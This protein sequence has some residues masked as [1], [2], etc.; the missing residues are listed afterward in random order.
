MPNIATIYVIC[1]A[2][3]NTMHNQINVQKCSAL[4]VFTQYVKQMEMEYVQINTF[5]YLI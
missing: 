3:N 4:C 1:T 5:L 2:G